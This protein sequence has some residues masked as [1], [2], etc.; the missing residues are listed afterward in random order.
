MIEEFKNDESEKKE[1][2]PKE[3]C[4]SAFVSNPVVVQAANNNYAEN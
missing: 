1:L 4:M 3:R 2:L